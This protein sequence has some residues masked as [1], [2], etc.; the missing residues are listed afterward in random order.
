MF[1]F[2]LRY[3]VNKS[4]ILQSK[5]NYESELIDYKPINKV[6]FTNLI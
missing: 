1:R 4:R 2:I 3:S 5:I 6:K